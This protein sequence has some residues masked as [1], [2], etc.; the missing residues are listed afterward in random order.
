MGGINLGLFSI[1]YSFSLLWQA[2]VAVE[3][4]PN[5]VAYR[6]QPNWL[7]GFILNTFT[8]CGE[9]GPRYFAVHELFA[10]Y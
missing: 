3:E 2:A 6:K 10:L 5:L 9:G 7:A 1:L 8:S 4:I